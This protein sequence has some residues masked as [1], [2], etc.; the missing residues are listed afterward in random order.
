MQEGN[1][2]YCR[3]AHVKFGSVRYMHNWGKLS[4][5]YRIDNYAH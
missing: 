5:E 3:L 4:I 1:N 2:F